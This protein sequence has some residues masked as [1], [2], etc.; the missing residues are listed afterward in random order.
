VPPSLQSRARPSPAR[1]TPPARSRS[2]LVLAA[3]GFVVYVGSIAGANWMIAHIGHQVQGAH[4][5]PVGFGLQAPSGVYM[6]ALTF[7]ARDIVQRLAGLRAGLVAILLGAVISW[8]VAS[9]AL[10]LASGATF[11][12]S[13]SCD[14]AVY[15]PLQVKN[16]PLAVVG[17]GLVSDG[18]DSTVF[19]LLAGIPLS[20]ALPGQLVGKAWVVL[21]GGLL[22]ALLRRTGPFKTPA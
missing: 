14:F 5:L 11:L 16:F 10:A 7:V 17:S 4:E 2:R 21:A 6:A 15:T 18:V 12:L 20:V 1:A 22:A 19:L 13:E 8:G 9:A 3:T